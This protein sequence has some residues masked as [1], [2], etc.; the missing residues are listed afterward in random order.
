M[1]EVCVP[2]SAGGCWVVSGLGRLWGARRAL[3]GGAVAYLG[4][5]LISQWICAELQRSDRR[6]R[7]WDEWTD[8]LLDSQG[9]IA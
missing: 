2:V 4:K 6:N 7:V 5:M 1:M 9:E 8:N 3:G